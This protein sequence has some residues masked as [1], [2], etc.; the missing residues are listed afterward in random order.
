VDDSSIKE[1]YNKER[2]RRVVII[3]RDTGSYYYEEEY[4][5]DDPMEMQ[6]CP[7]S[8]VLIGFYE[9]AE[10]AETV[11]RNSYEWLE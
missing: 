11:A 8:Q 5:S 4:F 3:R 9:T 7:L 2:N 6:W 10:I 1:I